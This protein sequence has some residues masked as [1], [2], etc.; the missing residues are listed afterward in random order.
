MPL[1]FPKSKIVKLKLY[2][3]MNFAGVVVKVDVEFI[4]IHFFFSLSFIVE[5]SIT[6][7]IM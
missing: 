3:G 7:V 2:K 4:H 1:A 6:Y 5:I